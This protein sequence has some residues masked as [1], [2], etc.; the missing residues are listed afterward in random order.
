[1]SRARGVE[2]D[3]VKDFGRYSAQIV[4]GDCAK[5]FLYWA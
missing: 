3:E 4:G 1:M 5:G 2:R